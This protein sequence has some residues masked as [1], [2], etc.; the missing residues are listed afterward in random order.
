MNRRETNW[1][2]KTG[3]P[4]CRAPSAQQSNSKRNYA[5]NWNRLS[6]RAPRRSRW[7]SAAAS[8][9]ERLPR[10][11]L[12]IKRSPLNLAVIGIRLA[13][14]VNASRPGDCKACKTTLAPVD[15]GA[16]PPSERL[17]VITLA[18]SKTAEHDNPDS[19]WTLDELAFA[20]V[21]ERANR[22]RFLRDLEELQRQAREEYLSDLACPTG[23]LVV[24]EPQPATP[25]RST[26]WRILE[27][28]DLKPHKSVYW[29]NSHDPDFDVKAEDICQLYLNARRFYEQG[30]LVFSSDEK[31]SMQ[32]LGRPY[33]TQ[34]A[35]P[36]KPAKVESDYIRY[37]TRCLLTT[38]CVPTGKV[39]WDLGPTRKAVDWTAHLRHVAG[40]FPNM[41]RYDWIVDNLNTH[42]SLEVCLLVAQLCDLEIDKRQL[43]TGKQRRAFLTDENHKYVFHFTPIH[44]SW[45]NQV[46]L[47]FSVLT[48]KFLRR[49]VFA[50]MAEFEV[51][52][53]AWLER[54]NSKHAHPYKWTYAGQPLVRGTPFSQTRR[55]QKQGRAW[56]GTRPS[57]FE[58]LLYPPRPYK[59]KKPE[60]AAN[61]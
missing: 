51:R 12:P 58:R 39:V 38:F 4:R 52:L 40:Q 47:F 5:P 57:L 11:T 22:E 2:R 50:S 46:E 29:L 33:P 37:G 16:F 20:F 45:L 17:S 25:S 15:P 9:C 32:A 26:I 48:R 34:E 31:T 30:R 3:G 21:N 14:G 44:G 61:L 35:Q 8:F 1:S 59:R 7:L 42:W 13:N 49:G 55:Q 24:G 18:T 23:P 6:V 28:A 41:N 53:L 56:F 60:L 54:Y 10:T 43:R 27:E 36:G 19:A